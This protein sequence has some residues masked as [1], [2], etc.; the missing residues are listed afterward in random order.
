MKLKSLDCPNCG[1]NVDIKNEEQKFVFCSQC[2]SKLAV[3]DGVQKIEHTHKGE[4]T[5]KVEDLEKLEELKTHLKTAGGGSQLSKAASLA[6][7]GFLA[8]RTGDIEKADQKFDEAVD[9]YHEC[10]LALLGKVITG[11]ASTNQAYVEMLQEG[12]LTDVEKN[13]LK[14]HKDLSNLF[15]CVFAKSG[16]AEHMQFL[17]SVL[18]E[19]DAVY[20][21]DRAHEGEPTYYNGYTPLQ[22]A[23]MFYKTPI[24][25]MLLDCGADPNV[26][27]SNQTPM[28]LL[29]ESY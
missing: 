24:V 3:D 17:I 1:N 16:L 21:L 13:V 7:S 5:H 14:K 18:T 28:G 10:R 26:I 15:A 22:N 8:L 19:I 27:A 11:N 29:A 12:A 23:V 6:E 20:I 2:G 4:V 9:I 25:Q